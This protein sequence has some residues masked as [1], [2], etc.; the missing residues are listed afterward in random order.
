MAE[1][2][3]KLSLRVN[4]E[5][6]EAPSGATVLDLLAQLGLAGPVAAEVNGEIVVRAKHAEHQLADGDVIELVHFVGGG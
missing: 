4:G 3:S 5:P 1:M 6:T 2:T